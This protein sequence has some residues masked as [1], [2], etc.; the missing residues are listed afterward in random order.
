MLR[1][2]AHWTEQGR[3]AAYLLVTRGEA[4]MDGTT[5]GVTVV[6]FLDHREGRVEDGSALCRDIATAI[7][8]QPRSC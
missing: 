4:G 1:P 8:R 2:L 3:E 5:V 6:E 7:R